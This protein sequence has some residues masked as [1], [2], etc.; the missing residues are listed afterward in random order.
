MVNKINI[1][2][3][4]DE[5]LSEENKRILKLSELPW[6]DY[7]ADKNYGRD[8]STMCEECV[9]QQIKEHGQRVIPCKGLADAKSMLGDEVYEDLVSTYTEEETEL[10]NAIYDPYAYMEAY[11]DSEKK[12]KKDR[13]FIRR[14][15]QERVIRCLSGDSNVLMADGSYKFIKDVQVGEKVISYNETRRSLPKQRITNKWYSGKKEVYRISLENGDFLDATE[16]HPILAWVQKGKSNKLLGCLSYKTDYL[17]IKDGLKVGM[18]VYTL[19]K[20]PT[21]GK[22]DNKHL[23]KIL[24]YLITDGYINLDKRKV[25]FTNT[26]KLYVDEFKKAVEYLFQDVVSVYTKPSTSE[27]LESY[28]ARVLF[29]KGS[30]NL[31]NFLYSIEA[32]DKYT[33]EEKIF[34]YVL[35][36]TSEGF[37]GIFLNRAYAG[38]GS[39]YDIEDKLSG[40]VSLHGGY[41]SFLIT[42]WFRLLR[43]IGVQKVSTYH[44]ENDD[45][46]NGVAIIRQIDSLKT[47]FNLVG[48]IYGKEERSQRLIDKINQVERKSKRG[49]FNTTTRTKIVSIDL[50][51]TKD[52]Y[53]I[54]VETR[55][56]FI[57]NNIVVHNCTAQSKVVRMGRRT[58]KT[59]ALAILILHKVL[60]N[61]NFRVLLVSPF[62]VQTEEVVD[63]IKNLCTLLPENPL[64]SSKASPNHVL[65]FN[66]G[67]VLKG[68]TASTDANSVRGQPGHLLVLDEI[69]DIPEK[70]M[71]SIMGIK[72]DNPN[73]EIWRSG[74]PKGEMNLHK[75]EQDIT[76]KSFHYPSFVIPHYD[77][78]LDK[79]LREELGEIGFVQE[80]MAE[81][82][83]VSN[84]VFQTMFLQQAQQRIQFITVEDVLKDRNRYIITIGVDWNHDQVGT[85]IV[86]IA[87]DKL[88]PQFKIIEKAAVS[89]VGYTQQAAM[90]K[91]IHLNRKYNADHIFCDEGF[92]AT[93]IGDLKRV[94]EAAVGVLPKGH[95]DL[96]LLD[97]QA[98]NFSSNT[99]FKDP[100]SG[101][102]YKTPTK[103]FAVQNTVVM[104]ERDLLSL[105]PKEDNDIILQMKNYIEKSRNKGKIV[106]SY[107]SK[108]IGDHDLDALMI[109]LY[110]YRKIYSTLFEGSVFQAMIKFANKA[111]PN[112]D[113]SGTTPETFSEDI[114]P[115]VQIKFSKAPKHF[116]SRT[117]KMGGLNSRNRSSFR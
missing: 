97:V 64:V 27:R 60:T 19:N 23:A 68:F 50:I 67:S 85:R 45:G 71:I 115:H 55:H 63:N 42:N 105:H 93:Q 66:T 61:T 73:V 84:G 22:E 30:S 54:E 65:T 7:L 99:E 72:M 29:N 33:R 113:G 10:L 48:P 62:A 12:G 77:D 96:K 56:N 114:L 47:F 52:T 4:T 103:Q 82:G 75:A 83:L 104:L 80:T 20:S 95:P 90:E 34:N 87:Y 35:N 74:T 6:R 15:Y 108:K 57:A 81:F 100:I 69:D 8:I 37:I 94:G 5:G 39:V 59:M 106:Y 21:F 3:D 78:K 98:V 112:L 24:G 70:A 25:E 102:V 79:E 38:D 53:D 92:G 43:K 116:S 26:N 111:D 58:G 117:S 46:N 9:A 49:S 31:Y 17:S 13:R 89:Q 76:S 14:W 1:V 101:D 110:G 32:V 44:Y 11:L 91:I 109:G 2:E 40:N 86:V 88:N 28:T 51:G 36:N 41:N 107:I 18:D 16:D